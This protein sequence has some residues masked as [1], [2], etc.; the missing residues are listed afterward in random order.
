[1]VPTP[2]ILRLRS[3][4]SEIPDRQDVF[5]VAGGRVVDTRGHPERVDDPG[6]GT[7]SREP[8]DFLERRAPG[9]ATSSRRWRKRRARPTCGRRVCPA[10]SGDCR[11]SA[12]TRSSRAHRPTLPTAS[13]SLLLVFL[14]EQIYEGGSI[15]ERLRVLR[16]AESV[17][18]NQ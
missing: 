12:S 13:R 18:R 2:L 7:P 11:N 4:P 14:W 9:R 17:L 10:L 5:V 6:T 16:D 8:D 3:R 1:M 15:L